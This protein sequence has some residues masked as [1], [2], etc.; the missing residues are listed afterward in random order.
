MSISPHQLLSFTVDYYDE[1]EQPVTV[2][3]ATR[4]LNATPASVAAG[5]DRLVECELLQGTDG[6]YRPTVTGRELLALDIDP[7]YAIVDPNCDE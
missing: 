4:Q 6:G 5:F 2:A 3:I 7:Q 1:H